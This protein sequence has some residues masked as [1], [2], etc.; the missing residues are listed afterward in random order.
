MSAFGPDGL[1]T[2]YTNY[3]PGCNISAPG[4][5]AYHVINKWNSM[6]LST[7]P[8]E[9]PEDGRD[10]EYNKTGLDYGYMQGTSMACPHVSG[11]V[12]LALSYAKKLG[13]TFDRD[14]FKRMI[15]ASVNDID[16]R[17]AATSSK[18]YAY[19]HADLSM[20]PY[21]HQMGTGAID[22]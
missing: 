8:S 9:L 15:L 5:E 21:Y 18:K 20:A 4:G 16:Q 14:D 10:G 11:V 19:S 6:V 2:Y 12:A 17:I 22:A 3:G 13:K 7:V 1:P